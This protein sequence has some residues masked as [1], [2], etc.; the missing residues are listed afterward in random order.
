[1][2]FH[3]FPDLM[4]YSSDC[5]GEKQD[6]LTDKGRPIYWL[7]YLERHMIREVKKNS[8]GRRRQRRQN[9]KT[10][11]TRQKAHV[12]MWNKADIRAVPLS[13]GVNFSIS[14]LSEKRG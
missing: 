12:N 14:T 7:V 1:M 9:N 6:E 2:N 5:R 10:Y 4:N 13:W 8:R 3:L 11:Y